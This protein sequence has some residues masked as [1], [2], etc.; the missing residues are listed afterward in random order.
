MNS[1]AIGL[2]IAFTALTTALNFVK[3]PVPYMPTFSYMM[4]D[5]A[6]VVALLL[7]GAKQGVAVAF[8]STLITIIILPGPGGLFGPPYYFI[9]VSAMLLGVCIATKLVSEPDP[10]FRLTQKQ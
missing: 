2:I 10:S 4:G 3:I 7:Y 9:S 1:K 5:I 6:I 8:L